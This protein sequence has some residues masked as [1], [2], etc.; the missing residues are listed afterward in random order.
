MCYYH[1][2][3]RTIDV[4]VLQI[5]NDIIKFICNTTKK[6][7]A[8]QNNNLQFVL[9]LLLT[10]RVSAAYIEYNKNKKVKIYVIQFHRFIGLFCPVDIM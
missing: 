5:Y 10:R 3:F 8:T 7:F 1:T 4:Q 9:P 6:L 2:N